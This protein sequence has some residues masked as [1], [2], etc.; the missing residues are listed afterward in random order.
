MAANEADG[1]HVLQRFAVV[2][3]PALEVVEVDNVEVQ[4]FRSLPQFVVEQYS[5]EGFCQTPQTRKGTK[6][7]KR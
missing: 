3:V 6:E 2:S 5:S 7:G 1:T 4:G